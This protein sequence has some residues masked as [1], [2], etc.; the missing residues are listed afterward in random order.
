[1]VAVCEDVKIGKNK[2]KCYDMTHGFR[3]GVES[4]ELDDTYSNIVLDGTD[5]SK[6]DVAKLRVSEVKH[7]AETI[8]RLTYPDAYD[9]DG[10]LIVDNDDEDDSKKKA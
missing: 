10:N 3:V 6:E 1:M 4:G 2:I 5:L 8:I 7:L 9:S